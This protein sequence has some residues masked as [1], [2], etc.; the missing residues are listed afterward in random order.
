M[1]ETAELGRKTSQQ[2]Y[3][4][5]EPFLRVGLLTVQ[6]EL[7]ESDFP[8][9]V[10]LGGNDQLGCTEISNLLHEWMDP[11][12]LAANVYER[13]TQE[14][15]ERPRFWRYWRQLPARGRMG[16][17][18]R[19]WT[20][21]A[22][23]DRVVGEIDDVGLD[24]RVR[25]IQAFEKAL[26]DDGA[27]I[28]KF[29]L[30]MPK[31]ALK[32]RLRPAEK[33]PGR[34][35]RVLKEDRVI[36]KRYHD[37]KSVAER[38]LRQT[39][40]EESLWNVI[41]STDAN[42]RDVTVAQSINQLLIRRLARPAKSR[43]PSRVASTVAPD[44][45]T[46]L[47]GVSLSRKLAKDDYEKKL[48]RLWGRLAALS[49]EAHQRG[50][51]AVFAFEGWDAA[52]KGGAI[53][54]LTRAMDAAH[55]R[56]IPIAAPTDE[57]LAHHY[58]W[59]F[60]RHL[61]RAGHVAIFDRSWY[62]RILVERVEGFATEDEWKRAYTEINDFE[63]QLAH[64]GVVLLKFWM[65]L[66]RDEQLRRFKAR[67]KVPFKKYKITADDYRNRDR[68]NDYELAADEMIQRTSTDRARWHV[69]AANDKR[70][71]RIDVLKLVCRALS[72]AVK[73]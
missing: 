19:E 54:R 5:Q 31:K 67:E 41:E 61:P 7:R 18:L 47:D 37:M 49:E 30:H 38:V 59:R 50:I 22:I 48:K 13:L 1:F 28:L 52:G 68:W 36:L 9:L 42:Y 20:E 29:W 21:R 4:E 43:K 32:Q 65:H 63:G 40:R 11:R 24:R 45:I 44:P 69:V 64:R 66:S 58:L 23:I 73:K 62:G 70:S 15:A 34:A 6:Y 39:S 27:L 72:K 60:W 26:A 12:Y 25:N 71:A 53:R 55:Y 8:V 14:E 33:N 16:I 51:S 3:K 2:D 57:E 17:Y 35:W 46:V 56:V 10:V